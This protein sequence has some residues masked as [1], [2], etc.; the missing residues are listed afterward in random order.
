MF[1]DFLW[2][3]RTAIGS[4]RGNACN[5]GFPA[6]STGICWTASFSSQFESCLFPSPGAK[7]LRALRSLHSEAL[8][9]KDPIIGFNCRN[10]QQFPLCLLSLI[11]TNKY[12]DQP[13]RMM[14]NHAKIRLLYHSWFLLT[15]S[16]PSFLPLNYI[17]FLQHCIQ[18]RCSENN[19]LFILHIKSLIPVGNTSP[20][21]NLFELNS[22]QL[23]WINLLYLFSFAQSISIPKLIGSPS[24]LTSKQ[25]MTA[26]IGRC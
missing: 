13:L 9:P 16:L 15:F 8:D 23:F 19:Y 12:E 21:S 10:S 11:I 4:P 17:F 22:T 7:E 3:T 2:E 24:A 5:W 20:L 25:L 6:G 1:C 14:N 18:Q 26:K